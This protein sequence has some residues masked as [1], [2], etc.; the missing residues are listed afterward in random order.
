[1]RGFAK[2]WDGFGK[3]ARK[4]EVFGIF[5]RNPQTL[6]DFRTVSEILTDQPHQTRPSEFICGVRAQ[7]GFCSLIVLF[8]FLYQIVELNKNTRGCGMN[9]RK[10]RK[11]RIEAIKCANEIVQRRAAGESLVLIFD[12]LIRRG[13]ITIGYSSFARWVQKINA[14]EL[15]PIGRP[16]L[17][18][19][20]AASGARFET[21][22]D[23]VQQASPNPSDNSKPRAP[24]HGIAGLERS[25][26][27]NTTPNPDELF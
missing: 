22:T 7:W 19:S 26:P 6:R 4:R 20:D 11:G 8:M 24:R 18:S 23:E 21:P 9:I 1:M 5:A 17:I 13:D 27:I 10:H 25:A 15:T 2:E 14:G 3:N 16:A 12:D